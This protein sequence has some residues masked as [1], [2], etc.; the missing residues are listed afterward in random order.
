MTKVD[1][2]LVDAPV[3]VQSDTLPGPSLSSGEHAYRRLG[4]SNEWAQCIMDYRLESRYE[5]MSL[6]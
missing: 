4:K 1:S 5:S 2:Y 3:E 6:S